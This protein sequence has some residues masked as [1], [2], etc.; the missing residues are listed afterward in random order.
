MVEREGSFN[1]HQSTSC[2]TLM[3]IAQ[4][5]LTTHVGTGT[6][7]TPNKSFLNITTWRTVVKSGYRLLWGCGLLWGRASFTAGV[8]YGKGRLAFLSLS[9]TKASDPA[10]R[11]LGPICRMYW[12]GAA[13]QSSRQTGQYKEDKV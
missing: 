11:N 7:G 1:G 9:Q 4:F 12:L 10:L 5:L 13:S 2:S 3:Y 8:T 6:L